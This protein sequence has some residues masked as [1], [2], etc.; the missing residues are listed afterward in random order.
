MITFFC[1]NFYLYQ[2]KEEGNYLYLQKQFYLNKA[3]NFLHDIGFIYICD[4]ADS[5]VVLIIGK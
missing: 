3:Y 4:F 1:R 2:I 5:S